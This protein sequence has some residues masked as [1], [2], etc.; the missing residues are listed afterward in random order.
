[1]GGK[2]TRLIKQTNK[3]TATKPNTT[4]V[5]AGVFTGVRSWAVRKLQSKSKNFGQVVVAVLRH[6]PLIPALGEAE[7][8]DL[9]EFEAILV[10]KVSSWTASALTQR[11]PFSKNKQTNTKEFYRMN[12][13][14]YTSHRWGVICHG[15]GSHNSV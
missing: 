14:E 5:A 8:V 1:M 4:Q 15:V 2:P 11:N 6:M 13:L 12:M 7:Q 9:C 10:Y 3:Q